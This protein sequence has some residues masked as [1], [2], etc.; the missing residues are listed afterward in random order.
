SSHQGRGKYP[1][2]IRKNQRSYP[3]KIAR[4]QKNRSN[5]LYRDSDEIYNLETE[6]W[7]LET[8]FIIG[9]GWG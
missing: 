5:C 7:K 6:N 2:K 1:L 4:S 9:I 8:A 3:H